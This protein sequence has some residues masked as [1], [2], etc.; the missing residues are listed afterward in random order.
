MKLQVF[1]TTKSSAGSKQLP[2]QFEETVRVDLIKRAVL[3]K[4]NNDR[5]PYGAHPEA[6]KRSSSYVSKRR[7]AYK[8]TYGIGQSRT[9]RKVMSF[10]GQRFNWTG[11]FA[12]Q[13]V[14]GRRAHPPKADKIW[15][16]KINKKERLKAIRSALAAT[17]D[18]SLVALRGHQLPEGYPFIVETKFESLEKTK[19][20]KAALKTLGFSDDLQRAED[21]KVRAGKGKMRG[22]Y[23]KTKTSALLVVSDDCKLLRSA[24]NL[25]G[26]DIVKVTNL[27]AEV[28]APG[29]VPGRLTLFTDAAIDKL[30]K[31]SL[32][33]VKA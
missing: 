14:G 13:T 5:Q 21:R 7:H 19:D 22:R 32:Y 26:V 30:A 27:N 9:P 6:G 3:A 12:P 4:R 28:L 15:T 8:S 20:V 23:Y 10:R 2:K 33:G 25:P 24:N 11:A 16:Q 17:M 29:T 18:K 31:E 1:T